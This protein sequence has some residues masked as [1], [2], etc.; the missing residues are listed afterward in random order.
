MTSKEQGE[1][2][3]RM[4]GARDENADSPE[5]QLRCWSGKVCTPGSELL[6]PEESGKHNWWMIYRVI[7]KSKSHD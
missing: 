5:S 4:K 2:T 7:I 3:D 1:V 6:H